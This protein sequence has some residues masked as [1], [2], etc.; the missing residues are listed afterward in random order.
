MQKSNNNHNNLGN[1]IKRPA[2]IYQN[3]DLFWKQVEERRREQ[4]NKEHINQVRERKSKVLQIGA[5]NRKRM[6][7]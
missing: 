1:N 3:M 6:E 7:D 2:K 4:A 5:E